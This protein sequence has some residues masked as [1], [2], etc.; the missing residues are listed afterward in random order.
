MCECFWLESKFP[1]NGH[2]DDLDG[3]FY[4]ALFLMR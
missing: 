4:L 1:G 2:P 3:C